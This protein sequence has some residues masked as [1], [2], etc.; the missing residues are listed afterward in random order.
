MKNL[1]L[2]PD[3]RMRLW[4][5]VL[6]TIRSMRV[7]ARTWRATGTHKFLDGDRIEVSYTLNV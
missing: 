1:A 4:A 5:R 3:G 7:V 2:K 6:F